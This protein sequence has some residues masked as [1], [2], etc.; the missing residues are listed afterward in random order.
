ML[1]SASL[2]STLWNDDRIGMRDVT[3]VASYDVRCCAHAALRSTI[4][5]GAYIANSKLVVKE[6]VLQTLLRLT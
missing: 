4:A 1:H 5:L 3:V 6:V 2:G